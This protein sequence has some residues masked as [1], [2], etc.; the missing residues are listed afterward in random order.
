VL[1][2]DR[3]IQLIKK[4]SENKIPKKDNKIIGIG[5]DCA[6]IPKGNSSSYLI[7]TDAL[8]ENTH[9][10]LD[11]ITPEELAYK[12]IGI[13]ISD[14]AA[15]GGTPLFLFI[16]VGL[17][18]SLS[19][20]WLSKFIKSIN[21]VANLFGV[22]VLGGDT[23]RAQK[24]FF[25]NITVI[26]E[27]LNKHIKYRVNA[28]ANDIIAVTGILGDSKKGLDFILNNIE[29]KNKKYFYKK[30]YK[31]YIYH[32]EGGFL[33]AKKSVTSMMDVSDG[34]K[35][36]LTKLCK[37]SNVGAEV[38]V[39]KIPISNKL[40]HYFNNKLKARLYAASGGE[41]YVLLFTVKAKYFKSLQ[42]VYL[43]KFQNNIYEIGRILKHT[44]SVKF[45]NENQE[46]S[47]DV[48]NEFSHFL[49]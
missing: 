17:K 43:N 26:G 24:E 35:A 32:E 22:L 7:S 29:H 31:P 1:S 2:E 3:I 21:K 37:A 42:E 38:D 4:L 41:D 27:A 13:N 25:I 8:V 20:N 14:I 34:L 11:K 23:V 40:E 16:S 47:M 19:D 6:V 30:H 28:K 48:P 12:A 36:D 46:V 10:I 39:N 5:D 33:A 15:M 45:Y 18:N 44:A 9:F 49:S